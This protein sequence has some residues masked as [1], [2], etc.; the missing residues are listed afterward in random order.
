[1]SDTISGAALAD[2]I[3]RVTAYSVPGAYVTSSAGTFHVRNYGAV[4]DGTTND[5][6]AIQAAIDA[7]EVAGGTVLFDARTYA[8]TGLTIN[9]RGVTLQ[10]AG[11]N[12]FSTA[13]GTVLQYTGSTTGNWIEMNGDACALQDFE[14]DSALTMTAG[15]A[16]NIARVSGGIQGSRNRLSRLMIRKAF[17]GVNVY[18]IAYTHL[19]DVFIDAFTGNYGVRY[20]GDATYR[21]DNLFM[22]RV[23]SAAG[24]SG[25][26][27]FLVEGR[28]Y[29]V[30][31]TD[32]YFRAGVY[33]FH[34][35][36]YDGT[37]PYSVH[38]QRCPTE[39]NTSNGYYFEAIGYVLN[40]GSNAGIS[41][42]S[43]IRIGAGCIGT[44]VLNNVRSGAHAFHGVH[45][46]PS[47]ARVSITNGCFAANGVGT[48]NTYDGIYLAPNVENV[49]IIGNVCGGD[50]FAVPG[51]STSQRNGIT[52]SA[53]CNYYIV[54][55][56]DARG[57]TT[58][59]I[60]DGGGA[61]KVVADNL[62]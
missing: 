33:G 31:A 54:T 57:N 29:S 53:G 24:P 13:N 28:C 40:D 62:T 50:L 59:S 30:F 55:S 17:N 36:A 5:T 32:C 25:V 47:A 56:N 14:I 23:A 44:I 51:G 3:A 20:S 60:Q 27:C 4:G 52:I 12:S 35:R 39:L 41:S 45:I 22:E 43:G 61:N 9:G 11:R 21:T 6:T 46:E 2:R 16:I 49:Q 10:G 7:A 8:F 19:E 42:G 1:M 18:G 58:A 26:A 37:T 38:F 15:V 48:P 34:G